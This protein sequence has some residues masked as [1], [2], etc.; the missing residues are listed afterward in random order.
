LRSELVVVVTGVTVGPL[1]PGEVSPIRFVV[2]GDVVMTGEATGVATGCGA[3]ARGAETGWLVLVV[4]LPGAEAV[5]AVVSGVR[6]VTVES[7]L[8]GSTGPTRF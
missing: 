8:G 3:V 7:S 4:P 1:P 6:F 2:V 5:G